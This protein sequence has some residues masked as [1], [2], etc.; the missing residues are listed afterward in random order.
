M[1]ENSTPELTQEQIKRFELASAL[2]KEVIQELGI[3]D[4]T[5]YE[6]KDCSGFKCYFYKS[7]SKVVKLNM[8]LPL[9]FGVCSFC[10]FS[11]L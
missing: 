7:S 1:E 5:S 4:I 9:L 11:V 6:E 3:E 8:L 2:T 10:S